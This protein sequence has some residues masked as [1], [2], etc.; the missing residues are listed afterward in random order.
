[1]KVTYFL[2]DG[3]RH[4]TWP[5]AVK[6]PDGNAPWQ[7]FLVQVEGEHGDEH[8]LREVQRW[9]RWFP[10]FGSS[11]FRQHTRHRART[12]T[13]TRKAATSPSPLAAV[14]LETGILCNISTKPFQTSIDTSHSYLWACLLKRMK[15]M[16]KM[17]VTRWSS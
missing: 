10:C 3:G 2:G 15:I 5:F 16:V 9:R 17:R 8:C 14:S 13:F 4:E 12:M 11:I 7:Q 6:A 1:M